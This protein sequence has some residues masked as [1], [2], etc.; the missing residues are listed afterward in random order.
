MTTIARA[1]CGLTMAFLLFATGRAEEER[2]PEKP[3]SR[4][5]RHIEGWTVRVDPGQHVRHY[6]LTDHKEFFAEMSEAYFG[7]ND[8]FPFVLDSGAPDASR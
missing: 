5:V 1:F 6:A 2:E 7:M 8:F 4:S 3:T